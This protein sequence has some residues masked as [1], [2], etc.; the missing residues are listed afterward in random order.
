[1]IISIDAEKVFGKIQH[2][3]HKKKKKKL[4]KL[5]IQGNCLNLIKTIYEKPTANYMVKSESCSF[6]IRNKA[7][8]P[9]FATFIQHSTGSPRESNCQEKD[10]K[11]EREK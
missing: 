3:F 10:A 4:N 7:R 8:M 5:G 2:F 1:M 6:K 11:L 9:T